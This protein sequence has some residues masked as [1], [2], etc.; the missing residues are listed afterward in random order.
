MLS[1]NGHHR[2]G[3]LTLCLGKIRPV[4]SVRVLMRLTNWGI[5]EFIDGLI[6]GASIANLIGEF[7]SIRPTDLQRHFF[8]PPEALLKNFGLQRLMASPLRSSVGKR[9]LQ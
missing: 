6:D 1:P 7:W 5:S 2:M 4:Q 8:Y 3:H 9:L